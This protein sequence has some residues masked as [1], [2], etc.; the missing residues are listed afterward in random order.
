MR[1]GQEQE[2][3]QRLEPLEAE[4]ACAQ[5]ELAAAEA[6]VPATRARLAELRRDAQQVRHDLQEHIRAA[7]ALA[8]AVTRARRRLEAARRRR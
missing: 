6:R 3:R 7:R 5:Q 2:R 1:E 4:L 8:P